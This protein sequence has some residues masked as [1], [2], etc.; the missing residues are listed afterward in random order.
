LKTAEG[1]ERGQ[2]KKH[3]HG[4]ASKFTVKG[5]RQGVGGKKGDSSRNLTKKGRKGAFGPKEKVLGKVVCAE[6]TS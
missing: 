5:K 2:N 4:R 6:I 3:S 1:G